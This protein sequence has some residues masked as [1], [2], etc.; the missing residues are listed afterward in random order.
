MNRLGRLAAVAAGTGFLARRSY[1]R[2]GATS[3][4]VR[5]PITGDELMTDADL[6]ATRA[7]TIRAPAAHV[8]PWLAQ[9]GQDQGGFYSYD[10]LE[11]LVG[12]DINNAEQIVPEWQSV[13]VGAD[14]RLHPDLALVV[15]Q[16][17]PGRALVLSG[18]VPIGNAPAPYTFTWAFVLHESP[19]GTSR[20]IVRERY[21]YLR[22]WSVMIVEPVELISAIMSQRM[23]RGIRDRAEAAESTPP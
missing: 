22:W 4:E 19:S 14:V 5:S 6:T 11:N 8:W 13:D 1:L 3:A 17:D 2:W 9:L 7:I 10:R 21:S 15:A 16:V 20:L 18:G 23:L 12:C